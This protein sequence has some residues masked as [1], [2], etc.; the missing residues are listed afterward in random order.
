MLDAAPDTLGQRLRR[1]RQQLRMSQSQL[2]GD[3]IHPS[4][5]SLVEQDKR[6]PTAEVLAT[7]A[8]RLDCSPGY[9]RSG[10]DPDAAARLE[11]AAERAELHLLRGELRAALAATAQALSTPATTAASR[12]RLLAARARALR[13]DGQPTAAAELCRTLAA[14]ARARGSLAEELAWDAYRVECHLDEGDVAHP[15]HQAQA[16]LRSVTAAG[17]QGAVVHALVASAAARALESAGRYVEAREVLTDALA[18]QATGHDAARRAAMLQDASAHAE[19]AGT[20]REAGLLARAGVDVLAGRSDVEYA[21][22]LARR[23]RLLLRSAPPDLAAARSDLARAHDA[24]GSEERL[25]ADTDLDAARAALLAGELAR[26][27]ALTQRAIRRCSVGSLAWVGATTL[28]G[29]CLLAGGDAES[30]V[31]DYD[32]AAAALRAHSGRG[33]AVAWAEL[34]D[35]HLAL[36]RPGAAAEA[37]A[38]ALAAAGIRPLPGARAVLSRAAPDRSPPA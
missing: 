38:A 16:A 32:R 24:A 12:E 13:R 34:A 29:H 20:V 35:A 14:V 4:Y 27:A 18:E 9:L 21:R 2:A 11:L 10:D 15:L 5:V 19:E 1:R 8:A 26:A 25:L 36:G 33:A 3:D 7:L 30:A 28:R 6:A 37:G 22:L 17:A 23:G 31:A